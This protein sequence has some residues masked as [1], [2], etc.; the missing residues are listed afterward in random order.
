MYFRSFNASPGVVENNRTRCAKT[1]RRAPNS[2]AYESQRRTPSRVT[3]LNHSIAGHDRQLMLQWNG[4]GKNHTRTQIPE[5]LKSRV[6]A[7]P[8]IAPEPKTY[9]RRT[10]SWTPELIGWYGGRVGFGPCACYTVSN[11]VWQL[12]DQ[13]VAHFRRNILI[14]G[15]FGLLKPYYTCRW[16][17]IPRR[18][19]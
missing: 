13:N 3:S 15:L 7:G 18:R 9:R 4:V 14:I 12:S 11:N 1:A 6:R 2:N 5:L 10:T 16:I 17:F 8:K 19:W